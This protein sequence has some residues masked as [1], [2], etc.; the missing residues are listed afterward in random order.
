MDYL[1]LIS[2][3]AIAGAVYAL[4]EVLKKATK[5]NESVLRFVPLIALFL[6]A[7]AGVICYFFIPDIIPAA[8]VVVAIVIGA[9]SGL[10]ATGTNQIAKQLTKGGEDN[11]DGK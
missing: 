7:V 6:G 5:N 4:I 8:N 11:D 9:A 1:D 3:P 10:A 2:V